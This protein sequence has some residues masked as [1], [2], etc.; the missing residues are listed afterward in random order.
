VK[1]Y[2]STIGRKIAAGFSVVL[3]LLLALAGLTRVVLTEVGR[4]LQMFTASTAETA[5][6]AD[7]ETAMLNLRL[8]VEQWIAVPSA[9][10]EQKYAADKAELEKAFVRADEVFAGSERAEDILRAQR[11][12]GEYNGAFTKLRE[13]HARRTATVASGLEQPASAIVAGL[14]KVLGDAR[15]SGDQNTAVKSSN[16]LLSYF[17]ASAAAN[18][19]LLRSD[20]ETVTR[21]Q[22]AA[23]RLQR[24]VTGLLRDY[25][26]AAELDASLADAEKDALLKS[27]GDQIGRYIAGF[28]EVA[29]LAEQQNAIVRNDL[30]R[31]APLF[32]AQVAGVRKQVS[33]L[34]DAVGAAASAN[35]QRNQALVF[36]LAV[37]GIVL[38]GVCAW[39]IGRSVSRPIAAL[40]ARLTSGASFTSNAAAQVSGASKAMADGSSRQAAALEESSASLEEMAGMTKANADHAQRAK[41]IANQA[42]HAADTGT[43]DVKEMRT[44]MQAIVAS[45]SEI[46]KIIKTID[47]IAFQTNILALNAAVE[48]ARAGDAGLG[49]AVVAD[50][51]RALAQRSVQAARETAQK[52]SDATARSEQGAQISERVAKSLDEI[53]MRAREVDDI[54]GQIATAS[55]EQSQGITQV[56]GAVA[57]MDKVTQAN[58]ATAEQT[59]AAAAELDEQVAQLQRIVRELDVM[60]GG[61]KGETDEAASP[62]RIVSPVLPQSADKSVAPA[63]PKATPVKAKLKPLPV[64]SPA[65]VAEEEDGHGGWTPVETPA[66]AA[67][68]A[69]SANGNGTNGHGRSGHAAKPA[70]QEKSNRRPD[71]DENLRFFR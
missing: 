24:Q 58:A 7:L 70:V 55:H 65:P 21:F 3:L 56:T 13:L 32:S 18:S 31:I 63:A 60:V 59:S 1:R 51:V 48:A 17:E 45:S 38:G 62:D 9:E 28:A 22:D 29:S 54:I 4:D 41:Q 33:D 11:L 26:M 19:F 15:E 39:W 25:Q 53:T 40:A 23:Q 27:I 30:A 47:E 43:S 20:A 69:A 71:D 37:G 35:H 2:F 12:F 57:D 52:I 49:F 44:A 42:R 64:S 67:K 5:E 46:S 16:A 6:A 68:P 34:Q 36:A 10:L 61:T 8:D 14:N 66:N 50:E